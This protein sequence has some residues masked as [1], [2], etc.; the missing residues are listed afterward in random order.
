MENAAFT[1]A[2]DIGP[3]IAAVVA[4][5]LPHPRAATIG[6]P[7]EKPDFFKEIEPH[8]LN[9]TVRKYAVPINS[10]RYFAISLLI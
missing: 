8:T 2:P 7:V 3:K 1:W 6:P 5:A 4:M 9:P 10:D